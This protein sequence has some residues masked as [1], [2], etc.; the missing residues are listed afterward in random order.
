MPRKGEN[1]YKR[2]DGRWEGRYIISKS[3]N[4]KYK[5]GYVYASSYRDV[6]Q[7]LREKKSEE[8]HICNSKQCKADGFAITFSQLSEEWLNT[9][10]VQIKESSYAKYRNI[11]QSYVV[12]YYGNKKVYSLTADNLLSFSTELLAHGG[13]SGQGLSAK[14]VADTLSI[15]RN[16]LKYAEKKGIYIKCSGKEITVKQRA[17]KLVVLSAMDQAILTAFICDNLTARNL[18]I[19][20]CLFTG[21][22]VGEVCA[23]RWEDISFSE[24]TL[25]VHQTVQRIQNCNHIKPKTKVIITTPKSNCSIRTIPL[26]D[27][28]VGIIKS[29]AVV[30]EHGYILTGC[31][32]KITEP[33]IMENHFKKILEE[34]NLPPI[35]F[36]ALRH[37]FAT[38][39]I[40]AGFDV[41][42]LSE[43][44]GH[45]SVTITMNRYV[46]PSMELKRD[47]MQK[48]AGLLT[49]K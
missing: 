5:Y 39:C 15:I 37:T 26:T 45:A 27:E 2:K 4:R 10:Q 32:T 30:H 11:I 34:C 31:D 35:N 13:K 16:L 36:H 23:L 20:I 9:L 29:S 48:L 7:K 47:N 18:G 40:E 44:L 38:R 25:Y 46:H 3:Q 17:S 21:L 1:I 19:M 6:K 8:N 28:L 43:I 12:P 24:K 33:R 41:K 49:V 14:S 22:R 42:S